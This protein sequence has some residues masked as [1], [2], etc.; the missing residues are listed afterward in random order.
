MPGVWGRLR[1]LRSGQLLRV[2]ATPFVVELFVPDPVARF[3]EILPGTIAALP[4]CWTR[5]L[6]KRG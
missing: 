4:G 2:V 5:G 3:G 6:R 1:A